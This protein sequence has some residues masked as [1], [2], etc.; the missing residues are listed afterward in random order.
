MTEISQTEASQAEI[1]IYSNDALT[2]VLEAAFM[3]NQAIMQAVDA[4]VTI[5]LVRDF[6][7]HDG[8]GNWGD[9]TMPRVVDQ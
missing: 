2:P 5:E 1:S 4:G 6:R 9:Q 8:R 7:Y 3:L